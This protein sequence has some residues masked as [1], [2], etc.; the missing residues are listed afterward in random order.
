MKITNINVDLLLVFPTVSLRVPIRRS[1][2]MLP[3]FLLEQPKVNLI[4][5]SLT[6]IPRVVFIQRFSSANSASKS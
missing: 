6:N 2:V 4:Y 5:V 1:E 3:N